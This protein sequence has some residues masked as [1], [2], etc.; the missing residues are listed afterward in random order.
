MLSQVFKSAVELWSLYLP[1]FSSNNYSNILV[2]FYSPINELIQ[3]CF[4]IPLTPWFPMK[5]YTSCLI[6]EIRKK[7]PVKPY[8]Y[9]RIL[10]RSCPIWSWPIFGSWTQVSLPDT[11]KLPFEQQKDSMKQIIRSHCQ[12]EQVTIV[13]QETFIHQNSSSFQADQQL[14]YLLSCFHSQKRPT[15]E[16]NKAC[17]ISSK[18]FTRFY[19]EYLHGIPYIP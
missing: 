10:C 19:V 5:L 16:E 2:Q 8:F 12:T 9:R 1:H 14:S 3:F 18:F 17:G 13:Y 4:Q 7:L 6:L 15:P 11:K